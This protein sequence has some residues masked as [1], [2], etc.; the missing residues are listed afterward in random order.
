[1][2]TEGK[3]PV[4]ITQ[5]VLALLTTRK[6]AAE[7]VSQKVNVEKGAEKIRQKSAET[8][9]FINELMDELENYGDAVMSETDR[10]NNYQN[11]WRE[12]LKLIDTADS[13]ELQQRF[14]EMEITLATTYRTILDSKAEWPETL[15]KML[16]RQVRNIEAG[17]QTPEL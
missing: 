1:M 2:Q 7:R 13:V 15:Q 16:V 6:E 12:T 8:D 14:A 4:V 10:D 9:S 5:E 17:N 3:T 11:T